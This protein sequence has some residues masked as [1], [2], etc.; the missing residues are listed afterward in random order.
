MRPSTNLLA[1]AALAASGFAVAAPTTVTDINNGPHPGSAMHVSFDGGVGFRDLTVFEYVIGSTAPAGTFAAFCLQPLE[2]LT[3]PW[4]YDNG[5][6]FTDSQA[7]ALSKLFTGA[8]WQSSNYSTDGV[9]SDYQQAGLGMA[10]WEIMFDNGSVDFSSGIMQVTSDGYG[11]AAKAF[12]MASYNAGNT[13]IVPDLVRL[14]DPIRQ[15]L[16]I[17]VPEPTSYALMLAGLMAVG[18][19][20]RRRSR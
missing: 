7:N 1:V 15:D 6:T 4:V 3:L 13:S 17:A 12:A 20:A 16:V 10:V 11:G 9:V 5:G 8:N 19:V 14:T 2:F 18:F